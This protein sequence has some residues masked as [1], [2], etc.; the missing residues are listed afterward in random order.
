[1]QY[2][3]K[4]AEAEVS[5]TDEQLRELASPHPDLVVHDILL[6]EL[7]KKGFPFT[8]LKDHSVIT[9]WRDSEK[10]YWHVFAFW[11]SEVRS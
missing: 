7:K 8:S 10:S 1:M 5:F 11:I 2:F 6:G 9:Q 4:E 3:V